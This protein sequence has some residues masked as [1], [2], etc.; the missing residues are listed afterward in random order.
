VAVQ[1]EGR[2]INGVPTEWPVWINECAYSDSKP[3]LDRDIQLWINGTGGGVVWA[4]ATNFNKRANSRIAGEVDFYTNNG[5]TIISKSIFPA[6]VNPNDDYIC[7][8]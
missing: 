6:P 7:Y 2:Q 1:V 3:K 4:I 5:A 8:T